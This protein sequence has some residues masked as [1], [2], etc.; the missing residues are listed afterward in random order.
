VTNVLTNLGGKFKS[1]DFGGNISG[2]GK[3]GVAINMTRAWPD[4]VST[5]TITF[6]KVSGTWGNESEVLTQNAQGYLA[7]AH[8]FVGTTPGVGDALVTGYAGDGYKVPEPLT[9]ILL[10]FGL[11]SLAGVRRFH[12]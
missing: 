2:F 4:A 9:L 5:M 6:D 3:M 11:V 7:A 8:I 1:L 12:K 10:G